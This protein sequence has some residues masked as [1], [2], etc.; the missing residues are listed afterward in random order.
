MFFFQLDVPRIKKRNSLLETKRRPI[1]NELG[2]LIENEINGHPPQNFL[3]Y[4]LDENSPTDSIRS[5]MIKFSKLANLISPRT[6]QRLHLNPRRFRT[7]L[8]SSMAEQ[9]SSLEHIV[10][11]LDH[12]DTQNAKV[13]IETAS[14][15]VDSVEK[16][17][18]IVLR[19]LVDRFQGIIIESNNGKIPDDY[20]DKIINGDIT[21]LQTSELNIGG[22]DGC[23]R[24]I[25]KDGLCDFYPPLSC[26]LC[27]FF[28]A[29]DNAS[30]SKVKESIEA[31]LKNNNQILDTKTF[32]QFNE[33]LSAINVLDEKL[34]SNLYE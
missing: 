26:Y 21:H 32:S 16:A 1:S 27:P 12:S 29:L 30:H 33:I 23:G 11:I 5:L 20:A 10:E 7:T 28:A 17:T 15:I 22:I 2:K 31:Y 19:P 8:A 25:K 34:K 18:E 9:G 3:C 13:Y 4:W 24:D 6:G 14:T